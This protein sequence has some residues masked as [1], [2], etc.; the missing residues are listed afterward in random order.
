MYI[1]KIIKDKMLDEESHGYQMSSIGSYQYEGGDDDEVGE[2][3]PLLKTK[4]KGPE[5]GIDWKKYALLALCFFF[6]YKCNEALTYE[7]SIVRYGVILAALF[8]IGFICLEYF[9]YWDIYEYE[10]TNM[11][12]QEIGLLYWTY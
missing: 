8:H 11:V 12:W 10:I 5:P 1:E 4:N 2:D 3:V 9:V 6:P 7:S